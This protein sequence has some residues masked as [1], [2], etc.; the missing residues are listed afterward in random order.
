MNNLRVAVIGGG[1]AGFFAAIACAEADPAAEVVIVEATDKPLAK[2]LISGGGR[3]NLT[4]NCYNPAELVRNYPR[5]G[6]ELRGPYSRFAVADTIRWFEARGVKT[7]AEADGR[8]FPVTDDSATIANCLLSEARALGIKLWTSARVRSIR[9]EMS[10]EQVP[11]S[12][13]AFSLNCGSG[14]DERFS[15]VII[16]SGGGKGGYELAH[17]LGHTIVK[18]VPSLF[19]FEVRDPRLNGLLGLSFP[20]VG[21]ELR[22]KN[23]KKFSQAGPL[24]ITHWGLSGPAVIKLSAWAARDLYDESYKALLRINFQPGSKSEE[25]FEVL[26]NLKKTSAKKELGTVLPVEL[27]RRYWLRLLDCHGVGNG[28]VWADVPDK[29]LRKLAMEICQAEFQLK[30]KG[31]FKEEFVTCGGVSLKDVDCRT[32]E[33]KLCPGLY[34]AGEVLDIDGVTGGFNFQAAWTTGYIAG[35]NAAGASRCKV[36]L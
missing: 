1:A 7:K 2:V 26:K 24:L 17:A 25:V 28:L 35:T 32:M 20:L 10:S 33:S 3:C 16:A 30:G 36:A 23:G 15:R 19:T 6:K 9:C 21:L 11:S 13:N 31:V 14:E 12:Q 34:F 22:C 4:N 18:P 5:G 27:P 29:T 8:M